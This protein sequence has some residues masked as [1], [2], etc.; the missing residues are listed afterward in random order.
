MGTTQSDTS[1]KNLNSVKVAVSYPDGYLYQNSMLYVCI[2][3]NVSIIHDDVT[4][5]NVMIIM[6]SGFYLKKDGQRTALRDGDHIA[7]NGKITNLNKEKISQDKGEKII[8]DGYY[9]TKGK[10]MLVEKG[11]MTE[12]QRDVVLS[13]R[14]ALMKNGSYMKKGGKKMKLMEGDHFDVKGKMTKQNNK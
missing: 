13:N 3:G 10:L 4:L 7:Y 2:D 6:K 1:S 9:F 12:V 5:S 14:T 11:K 8:P